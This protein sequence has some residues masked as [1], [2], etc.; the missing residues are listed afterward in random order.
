M[1]TL[2]LIT[3]MVICGSEKS[4]RVRWCQI[5]LTWSH[6]VPG[7]LPFPVFTNFLAEFQYLDF[8]LKFST[9]PY[10][11]VF[12]HCLLTVSSTGSWSSKLYEVIR[13]DVLLTDVY[14][15]GNGDLSRGYIMCSDGVYYGR[16][17]FDEAREVCT[18]HGLRLW[19]PQP[20]LSNLYRS[21]E[22][23][24]QSRQRHIILLKMNQRLRRK[25][26]LLK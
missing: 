19:T 6:F 26:D 16:G 24:T 2:H 13:L 18:S 20:N 14:D 3:S 21:A 5:W 7:K 17:T 10:T 15:L 8:N 9:D 11:A 12:K 23:I 1:E 25:S 22:N 4:A